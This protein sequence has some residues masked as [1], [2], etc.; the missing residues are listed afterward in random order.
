[1]G[2]VF[3]S[4]GVECPKYEVVQRAPSESGIIRSAQISPLTVCT[5]GS[6]VGRK[7]DSSN[8]RKLAKYIGV[9]KAANERKE[10]ISMT[11]PVLTRSAADGESES[12]GI[13][14]F[15]MPASY[16][17]SSAPAPTN[18]AV[19]INEV[20]SRIVAVHSFSGSATEAA[21]AKKAKELIAE[22]RHLGYEVSGKHE[23]A[24]YNPPFTLPFLRTNEVWV[25]VAAL[26][27]RDD[28]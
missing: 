15:V 1:M 11:A 26:P 2:M 13:M 6:D 24:R 3:G 19:S 28:E 12:S 10:K 9:I 5:T 27:Q 14:S 7:D 17:A 22:L 18:G 25:P 16:D 4:I 21:S 20:P 8:F 23:L